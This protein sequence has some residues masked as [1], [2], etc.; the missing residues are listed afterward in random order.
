MKLVRTE[1]AI[2]HVLCHDMTQILPGDGKGSPR[3]KG[4]RFKKGH[5]VTAED[6]PVLLSMGKRSVY[7]WEMQPGMLHEN[8]AALR[9]YGIAVALEAGAI[10]FNA[11]AGFGGD[12][13]PR[14]GGRNAPG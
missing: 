10:N 14:G 6:V 3:F 8:D 4:P 11:L 12:D 9:L 2:G 5:V 7:V 13:L 1:D